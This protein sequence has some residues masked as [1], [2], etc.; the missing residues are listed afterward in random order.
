MRTKA[1]E[2]FNEMVK[3]AEGMEEYD[4]NG[5]GT[6]GYDTSVWYGDW[7]LAYVVDY[8]ASGEAQR[9]Q[10]VGTNEVWHNS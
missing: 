8:D 6:R 3:R 7:V 9:V 10:L 1:R 5:G 4:S 2:T